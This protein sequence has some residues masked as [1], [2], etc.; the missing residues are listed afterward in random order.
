LY[1]D[2]LTTIEVIITIDLPNQ[3]STPLCPCTT[4]TPGSSHR[5]PLGIVM[6]ADTMSSQPEDV[7]KGAVSSLLLSVCLSSISPLSL[8]SLLLFFLSQIPSYHLFYL[9]LHFIILFP[10]TLSVFHLFCIHHA[11]VRRE[12]YQKG[13]R[14]HISYVH[15]LSVFLT[16]SL[17]S[18]I[19]LF[20]F[21]S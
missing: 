21:R 17:T 3:L 1:I 9:L 20:I 16:H 2:L 8:F 13:K 15:F 10:H 12:V 7:T 4:R 6:L 18:F 14:M 11:T 19:N 5:P